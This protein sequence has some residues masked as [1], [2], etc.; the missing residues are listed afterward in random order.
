VNRK[1]LMVLLALVMVFSLA[2]CGGDKAPA[3]PG[4]T[5]PGTTTPGT[6]TPGGDAVT[7][8]QKYTW[9]LA[10]TYSTGTPMVDAYHEFARLLN[11]YSDGAITLNVF[12]D[13]SLMGENDAFLSVKSGELEFA[14]FGPSGFYLYSE[15]YGFMLAPFLIQS[16]EAYQRLYNS[17]LV[18]QA[19][20]TWRTEYNTRDVAGMVYRGFR[21]MSC[22]VPINSV[23]DLNGVKL[24]LND[25][26][27]W[28]DIW[29]TLGATTVPIALGELYT[30]IQNG[31]VQSSEGPWEQMKSLNLEE[32]QDYI[33]ETKHIC[34]S[35]GMWMAENVYQDLPAHYQEVVDRAGAEAVAY[36]REECV[37][38]EEGYRQALLDGGCEF[39]APDLTGFNE[40]AQDIFEKY[41][42]SSW[43]VTTLEEV[44]NI[45]AGK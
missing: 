2:A 40:K 39:I 37:A 32:V 45:M 3:D 42:A 10:T 33:I 13:S 44:Q 27:L 26:Q 14:G 18:Q 41:F 20:E 36:M 24:R 16:E 35:V 4:T 15:E 19:V 31:A 21:N 43:T 6:T 11:E 22:S 34:E 29:N 23:N 1:I 28:N 7:F 9:S 8:D 12:A 30:S 5:D 38:R 17:D 25:N